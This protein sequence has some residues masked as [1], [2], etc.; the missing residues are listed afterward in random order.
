MGIEQKK[1]NEACRVC[2]AFVLE[3]RTV[4]FSGFSFIIH[5]II[6]NE[7][8]CTAWLCFYRSFCELTNQLNVYSTHCFIPGRRW[9]RWGVARILLHIFRLLQKE[10]ENGWRVNRAN[11]GHFIVMFWKQNIF[12]LTSSW[13]S[14]CQILDIWDSFISLN[15]IKNIRHYRV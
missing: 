2:N 1:K 11:K 3:T 12:L 8:S 15:S 9:W 4:R 7:E 14:S 6:K 5:I 13:F 10:V